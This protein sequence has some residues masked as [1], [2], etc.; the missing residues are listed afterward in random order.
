MPDCIVTARSPKLPKYGAVGDPPA[1]ADSYQERNVGL[2]RTY[3]RQRADATIEPSVPLVIEIHERGIHEH[4]VSSGR[5]SVDVADQRSLDL[6]DRPGRA[7]RIAG[8]K[9][10]AAD[11]KIDLACLQV[12]ADMSVLSGPRQTAAVTAPVPVPTTLLAKA[13]P[14]TEAQRRLSSEPALALAPMT[15][16]VN[17]RQPTD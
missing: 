7:D 5:T 13:I 1:G 15:A 4:G 8:G 6:E 14:F 10:K 11:V 2:G 16:A 3:R 9:D 17:A 12:D